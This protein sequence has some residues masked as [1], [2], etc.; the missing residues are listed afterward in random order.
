MG[1]TFGQDLVWEKHLGEELHYTD[2]DVH[3]VLGDK[4]IT[5]GELVDLKVGSTMLLDCKPN[6]DII[7]RCGEAEITRGKL[8]RMGEK[9][10]VSILD[11]ITENSK[12]QTP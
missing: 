9:M 8:G 10:A 11:T 7:L 4:T 5:M 12:K 1:E 6:S 2:V 3:A